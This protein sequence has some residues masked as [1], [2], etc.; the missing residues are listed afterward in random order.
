MMRKIYPIL[1]ISIFI[2]VSNQAFA[3]KYKNK[4]ISLISFSVTIY[5]ETKQF[6]EKLSGN[7]PPYK[8][9]KADKIIGTIKEKTWAFLIDKL[10]EDNGM[11]ILP[12][13]TLGDSYSYDIYGF[14]DGNIN[15]ALKKGES[16]FYMKIEMYIGTASNPTNAVSYKNQKDTSLYPSQLQ[17]GQIMPKVTIDITTYSNNGILPVGRY[18]G[19]SAAPKPFDLTPY[20]LDGL[21]NTKNSFEPTTLMGIINEAIAEISIN[22][23]AE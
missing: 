20:V 12:L 19:I 4:E 14:P 23:L 8:N 22:I 17:D 5:P 16:K 1:I 15:K 6:L 9:P 11:F 13:N 7:F 2:S 21:V 10:Q 18:K 3:Q